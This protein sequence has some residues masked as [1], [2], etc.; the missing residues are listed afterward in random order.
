MCQSNVYAVERDAET[1]VL[2]DVASM[3]VDGDRITM[4]T[5]FGEPVSLEGR[6]K[7][8]N[9]MKHRIVLER[10]DAGES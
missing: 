2:E 1:L 3:R 7:E 4:Q 9:L 10:H 8:I 6:I 5:L